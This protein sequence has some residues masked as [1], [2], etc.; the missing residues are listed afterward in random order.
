MVLRHIVETVGRLLQVMVVERTLQD[1]L[2]EVM[3]VG[4]EDEVRG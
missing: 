3:M 4:F 2:Q 1:E